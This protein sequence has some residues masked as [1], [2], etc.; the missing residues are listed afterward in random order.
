MGFSCEYVDRSYTIAVE[1]FDQTASNSLPFTLEIHPK[2]TWS[3]KSLNRWINSQFVGSQI[4][5]DW[6]IETENH[7]SEVVLYPIQLISAVCPSK[8]PTRSP[9]LVQLL[10]NFFL[11]WLEYKKE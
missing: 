3:L 6:S 4:Q 8:V 2:P 11:A 5:Q 10:S 1:S 7:L 9:E